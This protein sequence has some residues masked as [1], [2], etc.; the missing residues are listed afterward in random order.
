MVNKSQEDEGRRNYHRGEYI[1][2]INR[3]IDHIESHYEETLQLEELAGVAN[4]SP[5]HFHRIFKALVGETLNRFINRIRIEK[6]AAKLIDNPNKSITEIAFDYGFSG[7]ASFARAFREAFHMSASEWRDG[8]YHQNSNF[9]KTNSKEYQSF[10]KVRKDFELSS[11]YIDDQTQNQ[12][13]RMKMKNKNQVKI[14]VK[15]MPDFHVAY[16]RNIGPYQGDSALFQGMF[17]KLMKWAGP[18][19][20]IRFPETTMMCVYHDDPKI[21]Q[22]DKQRVSVCI[23]VPEDTAVEG[24]VGKI[25]VPGGKFAVARFEISADEYGEAWD[26]VAGGWL[27]ES[28][29]QPADGPCYEIYRNDPKTH[30]ENLYIVDICMPVQP[31]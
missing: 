16:V 19:G 4:F 25:V 20:L 5:F 13:W 24:E 7:S 3:V 23:T 15:D 29:Y 21:T 28:G 31:L 12:I 17:E 8:G 9:G 6:S 2:R 10:S 14:E 27:P 18:R 1:S 30:P 22:E 11:F 26:M